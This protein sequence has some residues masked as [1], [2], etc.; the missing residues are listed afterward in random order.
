MRK[1]N[2]LIK[3]IL[4]KTF[5]VFC[6][7][8]VLLNFVRLNYFKPVIERKISKAIELPIKINGDIQLGYVGIFP[9]IALKNVVVKD[10]LIE[11]LEMS[12]SWVKPNDG[13]IWHF[14]ADAHG[15]KLQGK[16]LGD[17]K[18][19]LYPYKD[20]F[21]IPKIKGDI[22]GAEVEGNLKYLGNDFVSKLK[23]A[24]LSYKNF[25]D[26]FE[27]EFDL[28]LEIKGKGSN[29][30][31]IIRTLSGNALFV[32]DRGKIKNSALKL[33]GAD[34]IATILSGKSDLLKLN[35][36]V[37]DLDISNGIVGTKAFAIDTNEVVISGKGTINLTDETIK[38][39]IIPKPQNPSFINM[40]T[41]LN[42]S[43]S[44]WNPV[45]V[46]EARDMAKKIGSI[47]LST[48]NPVAAVLP[49]IEQELS[50]KASLCDKYLKEKN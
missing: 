19:L 30:N 34:L 27:G 21:D 39:R 23:V 47:V 11:K 40:N 24:G 43:G 18:F 5:I 6:L 10:V 3:L 38:M 26:D 13:S 50:N 28:D 42:L 44:L 9:A 31:Q 29:Y 1:K 45:A 48:V 2:I 20:G 49:L 37:A 35:C 33:W 41:A 25:S 12:P 8:V 14:Y 46:P 15:L 36:V 16:N 22:E 7:V 17:Y 4:S 32:G